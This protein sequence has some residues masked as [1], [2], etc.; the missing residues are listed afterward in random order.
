MQQLFI[1]N[2]NYSSWSLRPWLLMRQLGIPFEEV[3]LRLNFDE[4]SDFKRQLLLVSPVGRVPVLVD[5]G[6]AVWDS[7]A[8]A[9]YLAD[10]YPEKR[11]WPTSR[12]S[13]ARAR[14]LCAEMHTGF[15]ALRTHCTMNLEAS[16]ADIGAQL[17]AERHDVR[18]DLQRIDQLWTEQLAASGGPFLF[19]DFSIADAYFAPV[20][21]RIRTY[22]LPVSDAASMYV[23]HMLALPASRAWYE[24]ALQEHDFLAFD[25]LY[26]QAPAA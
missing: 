1:G 11:L 17:L 26:R 25:E 10:K 19:Q 24:D 7:L 8:I 18:H 15:D 9:E 16:L 2:K 21:T 23:D 6:F 20:C 3:K 4:D 5:D 14:S 13:R 22:G 12:L